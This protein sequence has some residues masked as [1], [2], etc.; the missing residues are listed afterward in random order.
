MAR[1]PEWPFLLANR[2][3]YPTADS[4]LYGKGVLSN[5]M[6]FAL[7]KRHLPAGSEL[8]CASSTYDVAASESSRQAARP[9]LDL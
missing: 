4:S 9:H 7:D 8:A 6:G 2:S 5:G 3:K 1:M